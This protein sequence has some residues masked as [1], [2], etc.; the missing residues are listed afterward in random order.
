MT[1]RATIESTI[2]STYAARTKGDLDGTMANFADD[3]VFELNGRG[4]GLPGMGAQILTKNAIRPVMQQLIDNFRFADWKEIA[5][6]VDG[7]RAFLHWRATVTSPVTGKSAEFDVFDLATI[8]D[9]KI[10]ALHQST[11]TA[12]VMSL[13]SA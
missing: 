13:V 11:D 6:L 8:R 10:V 12:M 5:M 1:E 3:A 9:G 2:R 7:D 4:A